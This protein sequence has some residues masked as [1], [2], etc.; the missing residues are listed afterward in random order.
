MARASDLAVRAGEGVVAKPWREVP[1]VVRATAAIL[2]T[3]RSASTTNT[4]SAIAMGSE[5]ATIRAT[6][7][8]GEFEAWAREA[9]PFTSRTARNY[10]A[11]ADFA[12]REPDELRRLA[13]LGPSKLYRLTALPPTR[14]RKLDLTTPIPIPG[15]DEEKPIETM[16]VPE[17]ARVVGGL[18]TP[19]SPKAPDQKAP[20]ELHLPPRRPRRPDRS[21]DRARPRS[22]PGRSQRTHRRAPRPDGVT[23]S[24]VRPLRRVPPAPT[25]RPETL[26]PRTSSRVKLKL[27]ERWSCPLFADTH[28]VVKRP[29]TAV[30]SGSRASSGAG[31]CCST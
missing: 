20:P 16:T 28:V 11:L 19:P 7:E 2:R 15:T 13:H 4:D 24:R 5:I 27:L 18:I 22:P 25:G 6:L 1:K 17:L 29:R 26:T 3:H 9:V 10:I 21:V 31:G 14:R 23:G 12:A 8:P 30:A